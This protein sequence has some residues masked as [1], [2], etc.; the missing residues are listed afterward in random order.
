MPAS[1]DML[2]PKPDGND[3]NRIPSKNIAMSEEEF[4]D[5]IKAL[6]LKIAEKGKAFDDSQIGHEA[7]KLEER[8]LLIKYISVVSPDR[9]A[10]CENYIRTPYDNSR[11]TIVYGNSNQKLMIYGTDGWSAVLTPEELSR[12]SKFNGIYGDTL[13][14]YEAEHGPIPNKGGSKS[15]STYN[16]YKEMAEYKAYNLLNTLA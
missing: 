7:F 11:Y 14:E 16:S 4:E 9:K 3:W 12:Y 1:N 15:V 13:R 6:A 5:A 2:V 10:A 8:D